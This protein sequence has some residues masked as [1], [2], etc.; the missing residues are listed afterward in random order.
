MGPCSFVS[1]VFSS[2]SVG[3]ASQRGKS[4]LSF[5]RVFLS[6]SFCLAHAVGAQDTIRYTVMMAKGP[7]GYTKA[8][9]DASGARNYYTEWNDR[10]RGPAITQRVMLGRDGFP[11][12][13]DIQGVDY[14]KSPV[15][16][17]YV[18][19][20]VTQAGAPWQ[21]SWKNNAESTSVARPA[22]A[23]DLPINDV[24][25]DVF[26]P[27]LLKAGQ[28]PLLPQG[29]ARA[30]KVRDVR[31]TIDGVPRTL[32]LYAV[33][34][35]GF[36]PSTFWADERGNNVAFGSSWWMT[37]RQGLES[38]QPQLLRAQASYDSARGSELAR[39]LIR[40]PKKVVAFRN[41]MVYDADSARM[42]AH[43]TVIVR[44]NR[45]AAVGPDGGVPIPADAEVVDVTGRTLL[46]G[47]WDMHV[48]L[49]DDDG[50]QHLAA[51]VTSVR[52][53]A[54]DIDET[55]KRKKAFEAGTLI[56]PRMNIAGFIDGPGP[57]A[58]PTKVLVSTADS[59]RAWVNRYADLGYQQIKVYSSLD[60]ALVAPIIA[61][62]H[63]RGLRVSGHVPNGM[64]AEEFV[65]AG[66]DEL[67]HV[68]FLFLN[69]WRDSV[70]DTR[71]PERFTA[72]AQ[73][74]ALLDLQSPRVQRFIQLLR[75]RGTV[76][77]PTLVTFEGMLVGRPGRM[78]PGSAEVAERMPPVIRRGMVAGGGLPV[79]DSLDQRYRDSYTAF[80]RMVKAMYEAG[81]KI[82]AGTDGFSGFA[83][84]RELELYS[85]AGI[86]N[87][88]V[89][90]I[91][92]I[93]AA[94]VMKRDKELGS[95]APGKLAD[96][97]IV[98]GRPDLRIADIR[99]VVYVMKDGKVYDPAQLY[100][101]VGV[102]PITPR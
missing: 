34:G 14:L 50:L 44:G 54:N 12:S 53:L 38:V 60:T 61:T 2:F 89:L 83:L 63:K 36:T 31:V 17:H 45:I 40:A 66:A 97:I 59:A 79:P 67:Q 68:N 102:A 98:D 37:I 55:L 26:E 25:I 90:K 78:D 70:K 3:A 20:S 72:P 9:T 87:L 43:R 62:A 7:A 51:G 75:D 35:F 27:L 56:G 96:L 15:E 32:T 1:V 48:H 46:P 91:A 22:P 5:R 41:A 4:M 65:R 33:H 73:R 30:E 57:Y 29:E 49:S 10:G 88:D 47:L 8:W 21:A 18:A 52:D 58:G 77:D 82:V 86:P 74:A 84:H 42:R 100:G 76:I 19:R 92:T 101:A 16:E 71:T 85:A 24:S 95:I 11:V 23:Y 69:F 6:G 93:D 28:L 64:T 94:R 81:V 99:R 80:G 39:K 13:V